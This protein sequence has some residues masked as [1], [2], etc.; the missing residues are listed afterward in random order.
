MVVRS[1]DQTLLAWAGDWL[2]MPYG[3]PRALRVPARVLLVDDDASFLELIPDL[4]QP[5][6]A[7][8]LPLPPAVPAARSC[9]G[10]WPS[11]T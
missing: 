8:Q 9:P 10:R 1:G 4:G 5:A 6:G 7:R 3:I 11:T 2:S